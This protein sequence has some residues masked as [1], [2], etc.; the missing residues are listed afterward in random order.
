MRG[1]Q[2]FATVFLHRAHVV[3]AP[4]IPWQGTKFLPAWRSSSMALVAGTEAVVRIH[5]ITAS[6]Y[7]KPMRKNRVLER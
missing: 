1:R 6:L 3:F 5:V 4:S 2:N 7:S